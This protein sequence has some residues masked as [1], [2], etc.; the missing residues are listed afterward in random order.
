VLKMIEEDPSIGLVLVEVNQGGDVWRSIFHDMPVPVVTRWQGVSKEIR[1]AR[2]L[3]D[4]QRKR[5]VHW[6]G[7]TTAEEQMV[8]FPKAPHDDIV[9]AVGTGTNFFLHRPK[10][11]RAAG[12]S[13]S[14]V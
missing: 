8:G 9:D 14:Y 2:A 11:K 6:E 7:L 4:Y 3:T 13:A 12:T 10:K 5:V 1:A